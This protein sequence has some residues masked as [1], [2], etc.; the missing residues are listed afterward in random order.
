LGISRVFADTLPIEL[1]ARPVKRA[2]QW[3]GL[4]V[5]YSQLDCVVTGSDVMRDLT[6][7]L[8]LKIRNEVIPNGVDLHRFHPGSDDASGSVRAALGIEPRDMMI[9]AVGAVIPRK[10]TDLL[11]AAW[12]RLAKRHPQAHLVVVGPRADTSNPELADFHRRLEVLIAACD[13]PERVHLTGKVDNVDAYLRASDIC[14]FPSKKEGVCN[15]VLEAMASGVPVI[16]TPHVGQ[17][18][19]L[20]S[21]L[22]RCGR[23]WVEEV[24]DLERTLDRYAVLYHSLADS[25]RAKHTSSPKVDFAPVL[26]EAEERRRSAE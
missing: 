14:V 19:E 15:A 5:L 16:L 25:T 26:R 9:T 13:A 20:R 4:R 12:I 7:G 10:G 21:R 17:N 18:G 6:L 8:G 23:R 24:M 22:G 1:P 2:A 11:L 3:G